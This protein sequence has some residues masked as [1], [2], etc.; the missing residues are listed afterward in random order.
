ML[1][2]ALYLSMSL[3]FF[4]AQ[5]ERKGWECPYAEV[6]C[7]LIIRVLSQG[8]QVS[9]SLSLQAEGTKLCSHASWTML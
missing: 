7:S 3:E 2:V 8:M 6:V 9:L 4:S 1:P 5:W